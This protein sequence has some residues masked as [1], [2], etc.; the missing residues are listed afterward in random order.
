MPLLPTVT[1][2]WCGGWAGINRRTKRALDS[3]SCREGDADNRAYLRLV[4]RRGMERWKGGTCRQ[5]NC[6]GGLAIKF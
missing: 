2:A 1:C 6:I 4:D 5:F 3:G